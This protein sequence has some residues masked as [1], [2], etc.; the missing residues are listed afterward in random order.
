MTDE[1]PAGKA[2]VTE[3]GMKI[4]EGQHT[5]YQVRKEGGR[6]SGR[7]GKY[8]GLC[9]CFGLIRSLSECVKPN[10]GLQPPPLSL[11][12]LCLAGGGGADGLPDGRAIELDGPPLA[13]LRRG[14]LASK[15]GGAR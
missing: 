13:W 15:G 1:V 3:P 12:T 7:A 10:S 4:A 6:E 5:P 8:G 2:G 14:Q 11:C 9:A